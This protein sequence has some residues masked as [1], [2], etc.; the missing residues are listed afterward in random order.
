[1]LADPRCRRGQI[2]STK[3]RFSL[4]SDRCGTFGDDALPVQLGGMVKHNLAVSGEVFGIE[5]LVLDVVF[6]E[7]VQ[8][9]LLAIDLRKAAKVA[10]P[11]KEIEGIIDETA[12]SARGKFCLEFGRVGPA[13]VDHHDLTIDDG[14][15]WYGRARRQT[16]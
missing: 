10:I 6:P 13:L 4:R 2:G 16:R 9:R 3:S 15:A 12:L 1:M 5:N 11:P 8:Q 14:F 7:K